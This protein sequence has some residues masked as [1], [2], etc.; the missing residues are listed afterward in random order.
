MTT[1][2]LIVIDIQND[3]FT[4]GLWPV[5][6]MDRVAENAAKALEKARTEGQKVI[7][8]RHEALSD[9]APFFRPGT[10]GA[11]IH[12][13]VAPRD[14][15]PVVLKHRPNSFHETDLHQRLQDAGVTAVTLVGAMSQ[16]CIDAT[17]RAARDLGYDVTVIADACGARE[18][19][20]GDTTISAPDVHAAFMGALQGAYAEVV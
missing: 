16:M 17:A 2:A 3:Y 12:P 15:E 9:E 7:F 11:E 19:S 8:I 14:G 4:G 13:S 20:M 18:V 1:T 10:E 6:E 5:H